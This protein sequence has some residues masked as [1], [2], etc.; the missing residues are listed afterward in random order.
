MILRQGD[1]TIPCSAGI[2]QLAWDAGLNSHRD[3][4]AATAAK[5]PNVRFA[6][7]SGAG[8]TERQ[9]LVDRWGC[10]WLYNEVASDGQCVGSPLAD[11]SGLSCW[12]MPDPDLYHDWNA[13]RADIERRRCAGELTY[14]GVE[15]GFLYLRLSYLRG[16]ENMLADVGDPSDAFLDLLDRMTTFWV[17]VA[18]RMADLQPD[19]AS[20]PDDLGM[21][22]SL[23][24]SPRSW[25]KLLKP[26]YARVFAPL[27]AA[28]GT[29]HMHTDGYIVDIIPDLVECGVGIL[30]PQDLVN[31]LDN[32]E[33]LA[34]GRTTIELD[35]DR[36][37][38]TA[39]GTPAEIRCHIAAC[40]EQ[41]GSPTGG[42][43]M[44]YGGY[45]G[46]PVENVEAVLL[47][48]QENHDRW[49]AR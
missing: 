12:E 48:M 41:L 4:L 28:G 25:R 42:L 23:P 5:C 31:G 36:Q 18:E 17:R 6:M 9:T 29:V 13:A 21:Q 26:V 2:D 15:H 43:S 33:R 49:V 16:F 45:G 46:T 35:I 7:P 10:T 3:R 38:A 37:S 24:M 1:G 11:W 14:M 22:H 40:A 47:G 44:V 32:L 20:F 8:R 30:N 19:I 34:K 27:R 39:F